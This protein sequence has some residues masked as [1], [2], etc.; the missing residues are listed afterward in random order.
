[1]CKDLGFIFY[2]DLLKE[3]NY[4]ICL[5]DHCRHS[6]GYVKSNK[7]DRESMDSKTNYSGFPFIPVRYK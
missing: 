1:M 2:K 7:N 6:C 3:A 4:T 5:Y